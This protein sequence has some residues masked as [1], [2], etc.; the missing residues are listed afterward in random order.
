MFV[1]AV[2]CW[3]SPIIFEFTGTVSDATTIASNG[4]ALFTT[5]PEWTGQLVTGTLTMTQRDF[6]RRIVVFLM[7]YSASAK[8]N[9]LMLLVGWLGLRYLAKLW[10]SFRGSLEN[11]I[12]DRNV[13][14]QTDNPF[15]IKQKSSQQSHNNDDKIK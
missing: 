6:S 2:P 11:F 13:A 5:H 14:L 8:I 15:L 4:Q 10:G 3:G 12:R 9:W 7:A 1:I